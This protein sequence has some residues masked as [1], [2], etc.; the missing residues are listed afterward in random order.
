MFGKTPKKKVNKESILSVVILIVIVAGIGI[1]V[2][3]QDEVDEDMMEGKI[4]QEREEEVGKD[5]EVEVEDG[6]EVEKDEDVVEPEE[7]EMVALSPGSYTTQVSSGEG[8]T[9]IARRALSNFE[10][11]GAAGELTNEHRIYI[12]DYVQMRMDVSFVQEGDSITISGDLLEEAVEK[13]HELTDAELQNLKQYSVL[14][15]S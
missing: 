15:F 11:T 2:T 14:V 6:E 1:F 12:E 8:R 5:E 4:H 10:E 3:L 7:T 13:A 9:H